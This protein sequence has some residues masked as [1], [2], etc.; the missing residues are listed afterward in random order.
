MTIEEKKIDIPYILNF[1]VL[2]LIGF[3][4]EIRL[5]DKKKKKTIR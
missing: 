1:K 2:N 4:A 3:V 5:R